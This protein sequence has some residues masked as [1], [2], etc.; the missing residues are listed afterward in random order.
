MVMKYPWIAE[1]IIDWG[2]DSCKY[3]GDE[4]ICNECSLRGEICDKLLEL[5]KIISQKIKEED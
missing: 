2:I 3:K 4:I 5:S 1:A